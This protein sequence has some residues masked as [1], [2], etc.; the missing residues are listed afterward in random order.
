MRKTSKSELNKLFKPYVLQLQTSIRNI[1]FVIDG[2]FLLHNISWPNGASFQEIC[3]MYHWHIINK[4]GENSS[5][6]FD[7][8]TDEYTGIKSYERYCRREENMAPDIEFN[9]STFLTLSQKKFLSNVKNKMKLVQMLVV[10]LRAH[11]FNVKLAQE[12]VDALITRTAIELRQNTGRE[13]AVVSNDTDLLILLIGLSNSNPLFFYKI[14]P[15]GKINTLYY[16][17][18]HAHLKSYILFAHAFAG[19]DTTSAMYGK[20]KKNV[21]SI[22]QKNDNLQNAVKIFYNATST[23]E[24]LCEC[25]E[26]IIAHLYNFKNPNQS[27]SDA[28]YEKFASLPTDT[29]VEIRLATLPPTQPVLREHVKRTFYQ[30]QSWLGNKLDARDWGWKQTTTMMIPIMNSKDSAPDNLLRMVQCSCPGNS[31]ASRCSCQKTGLLCTQLCKYCGGQSCSNFSTSTVENSAEIRVE[32]R[33]E[34][35]EDMARNEFFDIAA[36]IDDPP[37]VYNYEEFHENEQDNN[38]KI[39]YT[40]ASL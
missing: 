5:I 32:E 20:E 39:Q 36:E 37:E 25:A 15:G 40:Y 22:L 28:R 13:V 19:C 17:E 30:V 35:V 9:E 21:I 18:D 31:K 1:T 23:V 27:L 29:T 24:S 3:E 10:Y 12:N 33:D 7:G 34:D 2:G 14:M 4:Y 38:L 26:Q 16:T 11:G 8:Y 6:V